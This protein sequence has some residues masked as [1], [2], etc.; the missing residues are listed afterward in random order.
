M[1]N[2]LTAA[3]LATSATACTI[4]AAQAAVP[5]VAEDAYSLALYGSIIVYSSF[6][7]S[8]NFAQAY[9]RDDGQ[10]HLAVRWF[11]DASTGSVS[12]LIAYWFATAQG[13]TLGSTC[14]LITV[15]A[16]GWVKVLDL[17]RLILGRSVDVRDKEGK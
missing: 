3:I 11:V 2:I 15:T 7:G 12:G 17:V 9:L 14:V 1:R 6:L 10:K 4:A 5:K 13:W 8:I 16:L